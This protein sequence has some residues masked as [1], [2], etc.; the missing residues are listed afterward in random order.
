MV[1]ALLITGLWS[2][3]EA[4]LWF[5]VADV[6]VSYVAVRHGWRAASVAA[7]LAALCAVPGGALLHLW[8]SADPQRVHDLLVA[9]PAIDAA[10]IERTSH[11]YVEGGYAEMLRGSFG[12]TPYKLYA[13]AAGASN[14]PDAW[15][16]PFLLAS[17]LV[18]VPRFLIVG[19]SVAL[20]SRALSGWLSAGQRLAVLGACWAVFYGWYFVAMPG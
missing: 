16:A 3:S 17:F 5:I 19:L 15:L 1:I 8:T 2:F 20:V 4:I 9:L 11:A 12:G 10:L 14:P 7:I 6:P 13:A 18:R